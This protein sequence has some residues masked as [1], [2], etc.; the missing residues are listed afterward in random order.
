MNK[1]DK[2]KIEIKK[3]KNYEKQVLIMQLLIEKD[4]DYVW[5]SKAYV[6]ILEHKNE[7]TFVKERLMAGCIAT[8]YQKSVDPDM[9]I[10]YSDARSYLFLKP[11]MPE[12]FLDLFFK[13]VKK[14]DLEKEQKLLDRELK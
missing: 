11:H 9:D 6:Q 13:N 5:I 1:I 14:E 2:I 3:L 4:I 12:G 10:R 7:R 8:K